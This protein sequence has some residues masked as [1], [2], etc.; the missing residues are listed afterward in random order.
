MLWPVRLV[1]H[2]DEDISTAIRGILEG[3]GIAVRTGAECVSFASWPDGISVGVNCSA[4]EPDVIGSDVL[5]AVGRRP[6]TD[7]LGLDRADVAVDRKGY[8]KVDGSL[9]T[10]MDGIWAPTL[11][12]DLSP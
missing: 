7:D 8:I 6:N 1:S 9:A 2:E 10:S 4:G 11:L 3:E 5:L 12:G